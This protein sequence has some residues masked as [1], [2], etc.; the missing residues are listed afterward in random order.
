MYLVT[1]QLLR[2]VFGVCILGGIREKKIKQFAAQEH[3]VLLYKFHCSYSPSCQKKTVCLKQ[4]KN[5][6]TEQIIIWT[7][8]AE[9]PWEDPLN[10]YIMTF[11][12]VST[13]TCWIHQAYRI[14][15]AA[16]IIFQTESRTEIWG[17][18]RQGETLPWDEM[19]IRASPAILPQFLPLSAAAY[20]NTHRA[21]HHLPHSGAKMHTVAT[22]SSL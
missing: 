18:H 1:Y 5:S 13:H 11:S 4:K 19:F 10:G 6:A 8:E 3:H 21:M 17:S 7:L 20:T 9:R 12:L 2:I 22:L 14:R 16:L 15:Y